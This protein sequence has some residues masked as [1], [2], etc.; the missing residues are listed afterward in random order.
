MKLQT[1]IFIAFLFC[2]NII[3]A[4]TANPVSDLEVCDDN[5]DGNDTNGFY[6]NFILNTQTPAI[7]GSQSATDYTVTYYE[8]PSDATNNTNP[9]DSSNPYSN[10]IPNSQTIHA[11]ITDNNTNS[12]DTTSFDIVVNPLP[13]IVSVVELRQCD[14]NTDG[15][16]SFNLN[17]ASSDISTNFM[18]EDFRF[19]TSLSDA[20]NNT[21]EIVNSSNYNNITVTIDTVWARVINSLTGCFR[22][23][24]V[25]LIVS[26]T[27]IPSSFER[28]FSQCD[29]FLDING[30]DTVN[31][32]DTDG[33]STFDFSSV[34]QDVINLFPVSQQLTVT[35]YRNQA[36]ALAETNAI[37]DTANY[38]NIESPNMQQIYIRVDSNLDNDCLGFGAHITLTVN[39]VP[40]SN[41]VGNLELNDNSN[42]GDDTNGFVQNIDLNSQTSGILGSQSPAVFTVTYHTSLVDATTGANPLTSP[43]SNTVAFQ[44]TIYVRVTNLSTGCVNNLNTFDVIVNASSL[45]VQDESILNLSLYPNPIE[46]VFTLEI[47]NSLQEELTISLFNIQGKLIQK[48]T[49]TIIQNR[50]TMDVSKISNGVYF[51]KVKIAGNSTTKKIIVNHN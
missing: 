31:N 27:V 44:Q 36:D 50:A 17:E 35:Y 19:Y 10:I 51:I 29:D 39:P 24:Q 15:F 20:Q 38:R 45:S 33:I 41:L 2:I 32:D 26:T 18:N 13:I 11:R 12:F 21:N 9:I 37:T 48:E 28:N 4:Q 14:D 23:S 22:I 7:L 46:R 40:I 47:A 34:T 49:K 16:S 6:Q 43:F 1:F 25:N 5:S 42:D 3:I 8:S 30:N